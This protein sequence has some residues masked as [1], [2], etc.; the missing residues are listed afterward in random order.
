MSQPLRLNRSM[1][2]ATMTQVWHGAA[3]KQ[4]PTTNG[5]YFDAEGRHVITPASPALT[6][7]A[8]PPVA[9]ASQPTG[10]T[11]PGNPDSP[12]RVVFSHGGLKAKI[13]GVTYVRLADVGDEAGVDV[14]ASLTGAADD[15]ADEEEPAPA[16]MTD[17]AALADL[18]RVEGIGDVIQSQFARFGVTD[19]QALAGL[20][21]EEM[22]ELAER[23]F[24]DDPGRPLREKWVEKAIR[25]LA[26]LVPGAVSIVE[27]E[28]INAELSKAD[29]IAWA[30]REGPSLHW[31]KIRKGFADVLFVK[32]SDEVAAVDALIRD[33]L[34]TADE[35]R[36]G[37]PAKI[38]EAAA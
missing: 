7:G 28:P 9:A 23:M 2:F 17:R 14:P 24:P 27:P 32:V 34:I 6:N 21:K 4:P 37:E 35:A 29:L 8:R 19:I 30:K 12:Y 11:D 15:V 5:H 31:Q 1:P 18:T 36:R 22:A 20:S 13:N 26:E 25:V 3:Y 16:P 33:G 38:E 10:Y